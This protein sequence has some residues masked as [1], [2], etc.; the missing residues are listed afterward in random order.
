[1]KLTTQKTSCKEIAQDMDKR[2]VLYVDASEENRRLAKE[3][4][5]E[6]GL[7]PTEVSEAISLGL[8]RMT[9]AILQAYAEIQGLVLTGGIRLRLSVWNLAWEKCSCIRK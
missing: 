9:K 4:G 1:M 3:A 8:G 5:D 6:R 7:S 2:L